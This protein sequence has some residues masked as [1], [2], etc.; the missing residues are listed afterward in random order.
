MW[1]TGDALGASFA[2]LGDAAAFAGGLTM[3]PAALGAEAA[4]AAA[5]GAVEG[6]IVGDRWHHTAEGLVDDFA[7]RRLECYAAVCE[8][9]VLLH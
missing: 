4:S 9:R 1:L 5:Q 3:A 6:A 7:V 2:I 8:R